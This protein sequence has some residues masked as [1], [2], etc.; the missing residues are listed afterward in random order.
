MSDLADELVQARLPWISDRIQSWYDEARLVSQLA[1]DLAAEAQRVGDVGFGTD[2]RDAVDAALEPDP[3]A[4]ANRRL[5]LRN[6]GW[7]VTG[8]RF[9]ALDRAKPFVDIVATD[10]PPTPEGLATVAAAVL[11]AYARFEPL[12]LRVDAADPSALM[13]VLD[14]DPRFGPSGIDQYVVAGQ[15]SSVLAL[16]AP[17]GVSLRLGEPG[18]LAE[19]VAAIYARHPEESRLWAT[20]EGAE[21]L[22]E[23]AAQG[24][25]VEVRVDGVPLGVVAA[26][27]EDGHGM[28]GFCVQELCLDPAFRGRGLA[29]PAVRLLAERFQAR[30]GDV[31][32]GT[33]HPDNLPSLRQAQSLGREVVG[34]YLWV[35]PEGLPGMPQ[36]V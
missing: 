17:T 24:L 20:P 7:A 16:P 18:P 8:I 29:A 19:R 31:L 12:C 34:G 23:G 25:L 4:W 5:D 32:W 14:D 26:V 30:P 6:G 35:T 10:Q 13:A 27:R 3:L 33:I 28:S 22:A 1:H 2:Y 36:R 11:P 15:V 9:R 21:S